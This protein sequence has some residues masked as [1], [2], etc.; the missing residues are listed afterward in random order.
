MTFEQ[1]VAWSAKLDVELESSWAA[2][3]FAQAVAQA[4]DAAYVRSRLERLMLHPDESLYLDDALTRIVSASRSAVTDKKG[5]RHA[6]T[7]VA[8]LKATQKP[9]QPRR[10]PV[11]PKETSTLFCSPRTLSGS[12]QHSGY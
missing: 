10:Q 7:P 3:M 8:P 12:R 9:Q 5:S 11:E 6:Y 4:G 2:S 1:Y